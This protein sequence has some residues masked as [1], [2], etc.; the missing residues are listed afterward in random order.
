[1]SDSIEYLKEEVEY[2]KKKAC[3]Y[4][5]VLDHFFEYPQTV[6]DILKNAREEWERRTRGKDVMTMHAFVFAD[7]VASCTEEIWKEW[8]EDAKD[9]EE[10]VLK[11]E[12]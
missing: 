3:W 1:M 10:G 7:L 11:E 2:W 6:G 12:N 9:E 4:G 5:E 8:S